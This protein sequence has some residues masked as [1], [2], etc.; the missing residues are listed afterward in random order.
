MEGEK[1]REVVQMKGYFALA[2]LGLT[3]TLTACQAQDVEECSAAVP[4]TDVDA[5]ETVALDP[6]L[7]LL[8]ILVRP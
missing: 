5:V 8:E 7:N 6:L 2:L 4:S 3:M 1:G